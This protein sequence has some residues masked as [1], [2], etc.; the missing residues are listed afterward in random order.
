M[1]FKAFRMEM[2][3]HEHLQRHLMLIFDRSFAGPE[4]QWSV[5]ELDYQFQFMI[6]LLESERAET[7]YFSPPQTTNNQLSSLSI[8]LGDSFVYIVTLIHHLKHQFAA[9]YCQ[10]V[11]WSTEEKYRWSSQDGRIEHFDLLI[12]R[13]QTKYLS[14]DIHWNVR[15]LRDK[16]FSIDIK[17]KIKDKIDIEIPMGIWKINEQTHHFDLHLNNFEM[18]MK[19]L[20]N[21]ICQSIEF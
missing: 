18:E 15:L 1:F 7:N 2:K 14:I 13:Y 11:R 8:P 20:I 6:S 3:I 5:N 16:H 12:F 9:R 17:A 10:C 4:Q 21:I 19:I